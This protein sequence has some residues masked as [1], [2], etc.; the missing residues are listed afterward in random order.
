MVDASQ[1]NLSDCYLR[2]ELGWGCHKMEARRP[3]RRLGVA[4]SVYTRE[5][6]GRWRGRGKWRP[7]DSKVGWNSWVDEDV[8]LKY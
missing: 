5:M 4:Q 8:A 7:G 2:V 6:F 3:E 1:K